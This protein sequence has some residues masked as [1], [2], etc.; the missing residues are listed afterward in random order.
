MQ[1]RISIG[2]KD[3]VDRDDGGMQR[4]ISIGTKDIVDRDDGAKGWGAKIPRIPNK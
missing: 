3:I 1:R 4:R 2:T